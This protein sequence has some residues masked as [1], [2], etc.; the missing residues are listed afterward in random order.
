MLLT[1]KKGVAFRSKE[2]TKKK[3]VVKKGVKSAPLIKYL[4]CDDPPNLYS[5]DDDDAR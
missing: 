5:A 4:V 2:Q 1:S 3:G